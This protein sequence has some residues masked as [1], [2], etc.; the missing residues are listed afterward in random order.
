M[1]VKY[2]VSFPKHFFFL[3]Y[4]CMYVFLLFAV[5]V[6]VVDFFLAVTLDSSADYSMYLYDYSF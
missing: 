6:A 5:V 3:S 1:I 2:S 4:L